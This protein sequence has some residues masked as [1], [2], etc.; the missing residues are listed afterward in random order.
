MEELLKNIAESNP[1]IVAIS[2]VD[3]EGIIIY[4][5][6]KNGSN[7]DPE[8]LSVQL[9][10]PLNR[11]IELIQDVSGE[12]EDLEELIMFTTKHV[13]LS[14][15]LVNETYLVVLARKDALYGKVRF[16]VRSKLPEIIEAL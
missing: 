4:N 9:V 2:I 8:E 12:K 6:V 13:L 10:H 3:E 16:K 1:G 15:K 11:L 5:Y 14:Y 7:I